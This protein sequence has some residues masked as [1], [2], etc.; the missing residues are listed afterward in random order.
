VPADTLVLEGGVIIL[1]F[2]ERKK[3]SE[4]RAVLLDQWLI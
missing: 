2:G 1:L 4:L 3:E